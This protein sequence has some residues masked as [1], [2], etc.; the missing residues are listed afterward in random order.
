MDLFQKNKI[1]R[2]KEQRT[3]GTNGIQDGKRADL[4][5]IVSH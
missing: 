4:N 3:D 2:K 1:T 5:S